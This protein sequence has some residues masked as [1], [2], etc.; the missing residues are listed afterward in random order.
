MQRPNW[1]IWNSTSGWE[2]ALLSVWLFG[3]CVCVCVDFISKV[4]TSTHMTNCEFATHRVHPNQNQITNSSCM[5]MQRWWVYW[6]FLRWGNWHAWMAIQWSH[7]SNSFGIFPVRLNSKFNPMNRRV[8]I[9]SKLVNKS[10][11]E[12]LKYANES[13]NGTDI[14]IK[15]KLNRWTDVSWIWI[16]ASVQRPFLTNFAL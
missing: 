5:H 12:W 14:K 13:K 10:P 8:R 15:W 4:I 9:D 16:N 7:T 6:H 2:N 3:V 1:S 11:N